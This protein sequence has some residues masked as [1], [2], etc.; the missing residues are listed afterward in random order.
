MMEWWRMFCARYLV[1]GEQMGRSGVT[2]AV[3]RAAEYGRGRTGIRVGRGDE[4]DS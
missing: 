2:A 1:M 3:L 4:D